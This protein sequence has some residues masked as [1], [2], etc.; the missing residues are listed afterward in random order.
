MENE[1]QGEGVRPSFFQGERLLV[2]TGMLGFVLGAFCAVYIFITGGV[3]VTFYGVMITAGGL[4]Y[5][6]DYHTK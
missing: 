6:M 3:I 4:F 5:V 2:Y 1:M